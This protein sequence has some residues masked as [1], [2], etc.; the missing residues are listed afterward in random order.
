MKSTIFAILV[1][2][3]M[4]GL[5]LI[6]MNANTETPFQ[7]LS[8]AE[9]LTTQGAGSC[10]DWGIYESEWGEPCGDSDCRDHWWYSVSREGKEYRYCGVAA[11]DRDCRMVAAN[12]QTC[13]IKRVHLGP[14]CIAPPR[15]INL[16]IGSPE[17]FPGC[18][19]S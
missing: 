1:F 5:T 18:T 13:A 8:A 14:G 3:L 17:S 11:S 7:A 12:K 2:V 16:T 4:I 9:I 19:T 15:S 6:K 10:E